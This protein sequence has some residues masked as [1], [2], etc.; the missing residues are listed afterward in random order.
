MLELLCWVQRA[1]E[2]QHHSILDPEAWLK[3]HQ[4]ERTASWLHS[5]LRGP[6][7]LRWAREGRARAEALQAA[8]VVSYLLGPQAHSVP[9]SQ[10]HSTLAVSGALATVLSEGLGRLDFWDEV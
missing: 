10:H 5:F 1:R 8:V 4:A 9:S 7:R 2:R 3:G 6:L